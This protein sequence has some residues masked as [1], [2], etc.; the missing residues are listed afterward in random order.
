MDKTSFSV[1]P[2]STSRDNDPDVCAIRACSYGIFRNFSDSFIT[3]TDKI[4]SA[5]FRF[6]VEYSTLI[7]SDNFL[8]PFHFFHKAE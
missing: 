8:G 5:C 1:W 4:K 7:S 2:S 3:G 6:S